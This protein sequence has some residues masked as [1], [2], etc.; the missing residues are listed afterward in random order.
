MTIKMRARMEALGYIAVL[1]ATLLACKTKESGDKAK[2]PVHVSIVDSAAR[3]EIP[4]IKAADII[5]DYKAN[6]VRADAK[7]KDHTVKIVGF[8]GDIKKDI[9]GSSYITI[10]MG[11]A[12][13]F[14]RVQC[15]LADGQEQAAMNLSKG[16]GVGVRGRVAGLLGNV[17]VR[18]CEVFLTGD[19]LPGHH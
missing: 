11:A 8:V 7:W 16:Q 1:L 12:F 13:E 17:Q 6:E 18:E 9:V 2:P 14:P 19:I 5:A 10:G 4:T 3:A 15:S